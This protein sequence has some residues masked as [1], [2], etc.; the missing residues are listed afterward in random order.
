MNLLCEDVDE[1]NSIRLVH[2]SY[3]LR[4][5]SEKNGEF[6]VFGT[7][8]L[9][10]RVRETHVP[11][12]IGTFKSLAVPDQFE[13]SLINYFDRNLSHLMNYS[14]VQFAVGTHANDRRDVSR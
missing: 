11:V 3:K 5:Q 14:P 9:Y 8:I 10:A 4:L 13:P 12:M 7:I 6:K 1:L 2:A